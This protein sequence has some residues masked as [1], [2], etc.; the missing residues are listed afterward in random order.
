MYIFFPIVVIF[1]NSMK[2]NQN[3]NSK[4]VQLQRSRNYW[5]LYTIPK[6][7]TFYLAVE[8]EYV[9]VITLSV[10]VD[11]VVERVDEV[12]AGFGVDGIK[13]VCKF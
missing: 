11:F 8:V 7:A 6:H 1:Q 3:T 9:V 12:V 13:D 2:I 10:V 4:H 5:Q